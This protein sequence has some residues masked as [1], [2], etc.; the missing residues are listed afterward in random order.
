MPQ[1]LIRIDNSTL[2]PMSRTENPN[3][4]VLPRI[5]LPGDSYLH[6]LSTL[7]RS[8][9]AIPSALQ[10]SAS[11]APAAPPAVVTDPMRGS[12]Q[13]ALMANPEP[14]TN[15]SD[16]LHNIQE[17]GISRFL[18]IIKKYP[19]VIL[20]VLGAWLVWGRGYQT[21]LLRDVEK[22]MGITG[23]VSGAVAAAGVIFA[24]QHHSYD[25]NAAVFQTALRM[26]ISVVNGLTAVALI[27]FATVAVSNVHGEKETKTPPNPQ[28]S[29]NERT[30]IASVMIGV[31]LLLTIFAVM[32]LLFGWQALSKINDEDKR[33][34]NIKRRRQAAAY[35]NTAAYIDDY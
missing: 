34:K 18:Y 19:A 10:P 7:S 33:I 27:V 16:V 24:S 11:V 13:P 28:F 22:N 29:V 17:I 31:G 23:M 1:G 32:S 25:K 21:E 6:E 5:T 12:I 26:F 14:E 8:R 20:I 9:G 3:A 35:S 2:R 15:W 4:V 30:A